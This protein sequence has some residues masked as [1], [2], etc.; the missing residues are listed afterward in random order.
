MRG[1]PAER[2]SSRL[3][4]TSRCGFAEGPFPEHELLVELVATLPRDSLGKVLKQNLRA[5]VA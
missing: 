3:R 2:A 5:R 1:Q 4:S